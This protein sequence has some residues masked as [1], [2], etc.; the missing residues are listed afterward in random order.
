VIPAEAKPNPIPGFRK[1]AQVEENTGAMRFG[2]LSAEAMS[3]IDDASGR[4]TE[5]VSKEQA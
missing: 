4:R 2:P 5:F 3:A 1:V